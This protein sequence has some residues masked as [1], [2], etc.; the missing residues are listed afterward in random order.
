MTT[1][2]IELLRHG[3]VE[4]D[5]VFRGSTD[6][7]LSDTGW[8]QMERATQGDNTWDMIIS[9]PL[10]RC[11][12]F[13]N[14]LAERHRLPIDDR[15]AL[16]EIDFGR[17]EGCTPDDILVTDNQLLQDWWN[18][19]TQV[20][21]PKGESFQHFRCRVLECWQ[22]L[23]NEHKGQKLLLITHAGVIRIILMK[24]LGMQEENLFR[25][26]VDYANLTRIRVHHDE[27]GDWPSL[28]SHGNIEQT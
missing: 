9:S 7:K 16:Q 6:V 13:A 22:S 1:T 12:N 25:I 24:I 10:L 26:D 8:Q 28:I 3:Q 27:T 15:S 5:D 17:W 20:T 21:P 14:H 11:Q 23:L 4:G 19:P 2:I 18:N